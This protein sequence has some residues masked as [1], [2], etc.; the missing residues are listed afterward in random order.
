MSGYWQEGDD[1]DEIDVFEWISAEDLED[2]P[3]APLSGA[4]EVAAYSQLEGLPMERFAA[5]EYRP[6]PLRM[7]LQKGLK[8]PPPLDE[9]ED[10]RFAWE[11]LESI[12]SHGTGP[13]ALDGL[14]VIASLSSLRLLVAFVDGSLTEDMRAKGFNTCRRNEPLQV[15]LMRILRMPEAPGAICLA[16][17]WNWVP[18]NVTSNT[19][20]LNRRSYDV[21]FERAATGRPPLS[22]PPSTRERGAPLHYRLLEHD[23]GGLR[24]LVRAPTAATVPSVDAAELEGRGVELESVNYRDVGDLWGA[25]LPS[26]Y[27]GMQLADVGMAVRGT[28]NKGT[29]MDLQEVTLED[30]RL[31]RPAV[32]GDAERVL[33]GLVEVLRRI[34]AVAEC[35]GCKDRPLY[36][37]YLDADLRIISPIFDDD[38]GLDDVDDE[39]VKEVLDYVAGGLS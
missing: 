16:S 6:P 7:Q 23:C 30:L 27:A 32:A 17:V 38:F 34:R 20:A 37:Q 36:L 19:G 11:V 13:C 21:S 25:S 5:P 28:V 33:G 15:D 10:R 14:D 2:A 8:R 4:R 9:S 18:A 24:M 12:H 39:A 3:P 35:P 1:D 26:R 31:D 29:L 22:G